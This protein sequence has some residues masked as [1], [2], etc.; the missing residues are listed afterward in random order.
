[1]KTLL[2]IAIVAF[3]APSAAQV[4]KC[5]GAEG[6]VTYSDV[7]CSSGAASTV[8][9]NLDVNN[10]D[11]SGFRREVEAVNAA[12]ENEKLRQ[13]PP[14]ECQ[15]RFHPRNEKGK[16]LAYMAQ[17]ECIKNLLTQRNGAPA[18][19]LNYSMWKDHYDQTDS[20]RQAAANRAVSSMNAQEISRSNSAAAQR[21]LGVQGDR[22]LT[23]KPNITRTAL[24]CE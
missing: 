3:C 13:N 5:I 21:S 7:I 14:L 1:M 12:L 19:T 11:N 18:S 8:V 15:F 4:R 22:K 20:R 6:K 24:I 23:C 9:R 2:I 10:I 17:E 16:V